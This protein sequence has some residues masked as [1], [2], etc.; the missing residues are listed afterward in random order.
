MPHRIAAAL[1]APLLA[2]TLTACGG[3]DSDNLADLPA[4]ERDAKAASL[5]RDQLDLPDTTQDTQIVDFLHNICDLMDSY[6]G[7]TAGYVDA[8]ASLMKEAGY[9]TGDAPTVNVTAASAYCPEHMD[10]ATAGQGK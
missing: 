3:N 2:L 7:D 9:T 10:L 1:A 6:D 5:V 8:S 4:A